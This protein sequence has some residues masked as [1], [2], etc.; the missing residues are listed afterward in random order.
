VSI[1]SIA[2]FAY[3]EAWGSHRICASIAGYN[4]IEIM[5]RTI[6][7]TEMVEVTRKMSF[8]EM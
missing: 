5:L 2:E 1:A 7:A 6:A 4:G 3:L 8:H